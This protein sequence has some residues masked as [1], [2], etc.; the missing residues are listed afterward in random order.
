MR[1]DCLLPAI[2]IAL[3]SFAVIVVE[4]AATR[5]LSVV[6]WYHWAFLSVSLAMLGLGAPG[7]WFALRPPGP[8]MLQRLL[9]LSAFAIPL[10]MVAI[11]RWAH[12]FGA[13][14]VLFCMLC[15]LLPMLS[16]GGSICLLL[17]EG[18]GRRI[19][20]MYGFDLLG[21]CAGAGL[22]IPLLHV[23]PTPEL[24]AATGLFPLLAAWLL[25]RPPRWSL[26]AAGIIGILL[27][28]GDPLD[29]SVAKVYD[30]REHEVLY[31]RWTPTA[32]LAVF[33]GIFWWRD[34]GLA[35]LWGPGSKAPPVRI[36]Q[37][38]VEQDG[39][40]GMVITRFDGDLRPLSYLLYD[41]TTVGY[42]IARPRRVA[43]IGAGGGRD[44]LTALVAG[45][46]RVTAVEINPYLVEIVSERFAGVSGD[47]Y[48]RPGVEPIV[49]E[50]RSFLQ[51]TQERFDLIQISLIDSWAAT[52]AG[53]FAL[54]ENNL[55]TLEAYRHYW[56]RLTASGLVS[57]TRWIVGSMSIE[58]PR[59]LVLVEHALRAEGVSDPFA[60]IA[61]A[62]A[63][64]AATVLMSRR[65]FD[66]ALVRRLRDVCEERGFTL[67]HPGGPPGGTLMSQIVRDSDEVVRSV[68]VDLSPPSD[69]RPFF[70]H[71]L[72]V[73]RPVD[74]KLT[75]RLGINGEATRTL[76]ILMLAMAAITLALF[77]LPFLLWPREGRS[78]SLWRGSGYFAF[79][80]LGFMLVELPW[81]QRFILFLE[82]PSHA[83]TIVLASLLLGAGIG[84]LLSARLSVE[85]FARR[86]WLVLLPLGAL[87]LGL[88][89][90]FDAALGLPFAA[91]A[92]LTV[93]LL[94]PAAVPLGFFFPLGM[95]RFG[96]RHKAW[97]WAMNGASSVLAGVLS[98]ALAMQ[99]GLTSVTWGALACYALACLLMQGS[100]AAAETGEA[101][102]R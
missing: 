89:R 10:S 56:N 100:P 12:W 59:L 101:P 18:R 42:Q 45:A 95:L 80:G 34:P 20:R 96:D 70:F 32:R 15:L 90:L 31:E 84:S 23:V 67:L 25:D 53:A 102:V 83:T 50:G 6:L 69:D 81:L 94:A 85:V 74:R 49:S 30:E 21:A 37:R 46:E 86:A 97:F 36:E 27:V 55:Y 28:W 14:K 88:S 72:P 43:V 51:R 19:S 75:D 66:P 73:F 52:S 7:V 38:W 22:V 4:I 64:A 98:L 11:L 60:H 40:A 61:V 47:V 16:L 41:V 77:F 29:V 44:I 54:S 92:A 35:H 24:L 9:A 99:F 91:R 58:V 26:A 76:Q 68:P 17:I 3:T 63:S 8:R 33:D 71:V 62:Q 5:I 78:P 48:H 65:P 13:Y 39:S 87:N 1:R 82:H 57:T 2:A 79:I 93:T